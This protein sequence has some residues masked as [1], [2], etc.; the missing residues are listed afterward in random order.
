[1][2]TFFKTIAAAAVLAMGIASVPAVH[3]AGG[4]NN[5]PQG[6]AT[7]PGRMGNRNMM[8]PNGGNGGMMGMMHMMAQMSQMAGHC[9]QM[10]QSRMQP[11]NSQWQKHGQSGPERVILSFERRPGARERCS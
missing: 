7:E 6:S 2:S 3:A 1:M 9:N 4:Q 8:G 10:M 5:P 11:S